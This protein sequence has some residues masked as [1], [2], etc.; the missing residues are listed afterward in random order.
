MEKK[1]TGG[2]KTL[3]AFSLDHSIQETLGA[4]QES[5]TKDIFNELQ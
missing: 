3:T 4:T 2:K 5:S 1:N